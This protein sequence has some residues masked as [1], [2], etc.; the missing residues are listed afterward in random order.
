MTSVETLNMQGFTLTVQGTPALDLSGLQLLNRGLV[1]GDG[2]ANTITGTE[3][4]DYL[5]G[6]GGADVLSGGAGND[7]IDGDAG[8][9][10][11]Y[12]GTGGDWLSG[13]L[14]NDTLYGGQDGTGIDGFA[15]TF[16]FAASAALGPSNVD[17]IVG[18]EASGIDKLGLS[19][20][21]FAAILGGPTAGLDES[22]FRANAGGNPVDG[23]DHILF[24]TSTGT[25]FYDADGSGGAAAKI[26]FA[27]LVGMA[28]T[29]DFSDFVVNPPPPGP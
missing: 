17:R 16:V 5:S 20:T 12:G 1:R 8:A 13:G 10:I 28:G 29:L 21:I 24:D 18:F 15:D 6:A 23:N 11:L 22:E 27:T 19:S 4:N 7:R 9:D 2:S 26:A 25:L 3:G 14:G